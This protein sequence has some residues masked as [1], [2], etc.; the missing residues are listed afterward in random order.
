MTSLHAQNVTQSVESAASPTTITISPDT[1]SSSSIDVGADVGAITGGIIGAIAVLALLG[2]TAFFIWRRRKANRAFEE[3]KW[4]S[5]MERMTTTSF[6][7]P[8]IIRSGQGA[9]SVVALA[10]VPLLPTGRTSNRSRSRYSEIVDS[11]IRVPGPH[12]E[13]NVNGA[14]QGSSWERASFPA[15]DSHA[16]ERRGSDSD[17]RL[18]AARTNHFDHAQRGSES[19][20]SSTISPSET[21]GMRSPS[22]AWGG[23][24]AVR[25]APN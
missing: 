2:T 21:R 16:A 11:D 3:R 1:P 24:S 25:S 4:A 10:P 6:S 22:R 13:G 12:A 8:E 19:G 18:T 7:S 20:P 5:R 17:A 9:G 15:R 23:H 14:V